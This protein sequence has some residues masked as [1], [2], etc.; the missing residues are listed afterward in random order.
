MVC[1]QQESGEKGG[2][3]TSEAFLK[4]RHHNMR[5]SSV[6]NPPQ[7]RALSSRG[8]LKCAGMEQGLASPLIKHRFLRNNLDVK[9]HAMEM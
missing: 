8:V 7:K 9:G 2:V 4:S 1:P 5:V 3:F 6:I